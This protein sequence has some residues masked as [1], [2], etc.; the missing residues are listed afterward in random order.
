M[1]RTEARAI[2]LLGLVIAASLHAAPGPLG[3]AQMAWDASA[4]SLVL[5]G[6][7][8][9]MASAVNE[10]WIFE[11]GTGSWRLSSGPRPPMGSGPMAYDTRRGRSILL[12]TMDWFGGQKELSETWS[13]DCRAETWTRIETSGTPTAGLLGA[14]MAYDEKADRMIL[15]GGYSVWTGKAMRETW[16]L[17]PGNAAW[18]RVS[19]PSSPPGRNYQGMAWDGGSG[20]VAMWGGSASP[21]TWSFDAAAGTWTG[22][23]GA[24]TPPVV[25]YAGMVY[26]PARGSCLVYGGASVPGSR[27]GGELWE[28]L[29]TTATWRG[30]ETAG[31]PGPRAWHCMASAPELGKVFLYGGG[32]A[33]TSFTAGLWALDATTLV[34]ELIGPP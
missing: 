10:T 28:W 22:Q 5:H 13:F 4:K 3:Y 34:W 11:P 20:R 12:L 27:P 23:R 26:V 14:S 16:T 25:E 17:D 9:D 7:Q 18:K 29:G 32:P 21:D 1:P 24:Q 15:F 8:P 6:G 2:L 33:K 30:L 31:G 19:P